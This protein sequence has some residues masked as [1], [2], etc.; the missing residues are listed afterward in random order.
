M[1]KVSLFPYPT[2]ATCATCAYQIWSVLA[3][4]SYLEEIVKGWR[5]VTE[6]HKSEV[7]Y[8]T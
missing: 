1:N 3:Q 5:T 4:Y 6:E 8:V 2:H 7:A